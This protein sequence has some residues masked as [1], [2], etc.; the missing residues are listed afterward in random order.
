MGRGTRRIINILLTV[1]AIFVF[2]MGAEFYDDVIKPAFV[3]P[4]PTPTTP[5]P[6]R[7]PR[8]THTP[9]PNSLARTQEAERMK[10]NDDHLS[11]CR[12][13]F[14]VTTDHEGQSLCVYGDIYEV[15]HTNDSWTRVKFSAE[16]N[17]FFMHSTYFEY[18]DPDTGKLMGA[19]DCIQSTGIIEIY[20]GVPSMKITDPKICN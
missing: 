11:D 7:T 19:G 8:P 4:T 3:S 17:T 10:G 13:W 2:G 20:S 18:S 12:P 1:G 14:T 5:H 16:K 15:Y 6:T 9:A